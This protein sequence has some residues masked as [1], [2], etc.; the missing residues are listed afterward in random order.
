MR[1]SR[2]GFHVP[3]LLAGAFISLILSVALW[4]AAFSWLSSHTPDV[5]LDSEELAE[6]IGNRVINQIHREMPKI[7]EEAKAEIPAI[8]EREMETQLT[9]DRM[10]IAG[11]VFTVPDELMA[12]LKQNMQTNVENATARILDG[13]DSGLVAERFGADVCQ[14]VRETIQREM[15]GKTFTFLLLGRMPLTV[16]VHIR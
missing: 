14:L 7:I 10:E 15:D 6:I 4:V 12:Q 8:V 5:Y 11:F 13:I 3:S 16:R 9:S 2:R 1:K